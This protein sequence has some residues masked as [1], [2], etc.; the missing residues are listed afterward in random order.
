[1]TDISQL[2]FL[3]SDSEWARNM[4]RAL[5]TAESLTDALAIKILGQQGI[6]VNIA[7]QFLKLLRCTNIVM[8]RNNGWSID[9]D[10]RRM[11]LLEAREKAID[12]SDIHRLLI[13]I[14]NSQEYF[15]ARD[16]PHYLLTKA[17]Q[18]YHMA[19]IGV[20]QKSLSLY[21][22]SAESHD[23]GEIWLA[24]KLASEQQA[25]GVLPPNAIEP[26]YL[27]A[28]ALYRDGDIEA[29][30]SQFLKVVSSENRS[31]PVA[32]SLQLIGMIEANR[33]EFDKSLQHLTESIALYRE[34]SLN[35][36]L[37]WSL[38]CRALV[39]QR[40]DD[41]IGALKDL[42]LAIPLCFGDRKAKLLG[43]RAHIK[44]AMHNPRDAMLDLNL[45]IE[46]AKSETLPILLHQRGSLKLD[47]NEVDGALVD[48]NRA[49]ETCHDFL[50][51]HIL[52][53]RASLKRELGL[54]EE[55]LYDLN[56]ALSLLEGNSSKSANQAR[57]VL[58]NTRSVLNRDQGNF[59]EALKDIGKAVAIGGEDSNLNIEILLSRAK[60]IR[61][62]V[63]KLTNVIA[64]PAK[65]KVWYDIYISFARTYGSV[66]EW[67][68]AALMYLHA[69]NYAS[70]DFEQAKC[71]GGAGGA[72]EVLGMY[73]VAL[74]YLD[75]AKN[76]VPDDS[77]ILATLAKV[78]DELGYPIDETRQIFTSA[79]A[80]DRK[81]LWAISWF[82]LALSRAGLH[83]EAIA[84]AR[85][86]DIGSSS[87]PIILFNL[88][89][90]LDASPDNQDKKDALQIAIKARELANS[91]F[92]GL[93]K[94]LQ[95]R[96]VK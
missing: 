18:A 5:A 4:M 94:F 54:W 69:E 72:Y 55:A 37:I 78:K 31:E 82:A 63:S 35:N 1:M 91:H 29:A 75:K 45:A 66:K 38:R 22:E 28:L 90:V 80:A 84:Q 27:L 87:N 83:T 39:R 85:H 12:L 36:G 64:E 30:Y 33:D 58:L 56:Y 16:I 57:G 95:E 76:L 77:K 23:P 9:E 42:N 8:R 21:A 25:N 50:L 3:G 60:K 70:S 79:I 74:P 34:I 92:S 10:I 26:I 49:A 15:D 7:E 47:L 19:E 20:T 71:L 52:N 59:E 93:A 88:A 89:Q 2:D 24:G 81:N 53:T 11:L 68:L 61:K 44:R 14:S 67:R 13:D 40:T 48:L 41:L 43:L 46:L 73:S 62:F 65:R 32:R 86:S 51:V 17:G 96:G 6:E